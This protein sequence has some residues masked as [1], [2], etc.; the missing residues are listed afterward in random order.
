MTNATLTLLA[1]AAAA[2]AC[3]FEVA[4]FALVVYLLVF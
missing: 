2:A 1:A 3:V 4:G